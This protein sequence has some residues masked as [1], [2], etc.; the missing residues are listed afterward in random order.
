[1]GVDWADFDNE[2]EIAMRDRFLEVENALEAFNLRADLV[3][4]HGEAARELA[5][6]ASYAKAELVIVGV[7][8]RRGRARAIGGRMAARL[9]RHAPCS[10]L[11]V[12]NMMPEQTAL[13]VATGATHVLADPKLWPEALRDFTSRNAGRIVNLEV[14][15]SESGALMEA[16]A[17]PL[18]GVDYD[19]RDGRLT[20][21]LGFTR[22]LERHLSRSITNPHKVAVLSINGRDTALSVTHGG[23]QTLLT[24]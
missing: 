11:V 22:G 3:V 21:S 10:V 24:F 2:Y 4:L 15:D 1:M 12:P 23:G 6:F 20:I 17:Y 13:Q 7:R 8:R 5:D 16:T 14:D 9:M 19:H 18:L